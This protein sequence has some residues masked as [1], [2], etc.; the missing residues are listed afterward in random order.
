MRP[1]YAEMGLVPARDVE[2]I[3]DVPE[4]ATKCFYELHICFNRKVKL[5][6]SQN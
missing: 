2:M 1:I 5:C 3:S 4:T 6:P